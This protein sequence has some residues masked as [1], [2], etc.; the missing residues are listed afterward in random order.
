MSLRS[1][2][3]ASAAAEFS[4][5]RA[6]IRHILET[7]PEADLHDGR[8]G[9][10]SIAVLVQ[11][12]HGSHQR[13][14]ADPFADS[15]PTARVDQSKDWEDGRLARADLLRLNEEGWDRVQSA[16]GALE[17]S[18]LERIVTVRGAPRPWLHALIYHWGHYSYHYG[19]IVAQAKIATG[20]KWKIADASAAR[21]A[22]A[23]AV[24]AAR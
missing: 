8:G 7:L 20:G 19:Q 23:V 14:W 11:H 10:H 2:Y 1:D 5:W 24:A 4:A 13:R 18:D 16:L 6:A 15:S 9:T 17:D 21:P 12:L 3:L 22:H